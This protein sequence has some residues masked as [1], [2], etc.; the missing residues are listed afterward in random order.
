MCKFTKL[1]IEE[2]DL[3]IKW[4]SK[5]KS[6]GLNGLTVELYIFFWEEIREMLYNAF[7][8]CISSISFIFYCET[9]CYHLNP[10]TQ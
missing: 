5:G 7:L 10:K 9:V 1:R 3:A 2:L 4:V 6:P 8:E